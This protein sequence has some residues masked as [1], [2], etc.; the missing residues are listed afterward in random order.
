M[1][2]SAKIVGS[3]LARRPHL[4]HDG[5]PRQRGPDDL[6][7][8]HHHRCLHPRPVVSADLVHLGAV[9]SAG[10]IP[11][12]RGDAPQLPA[13]EAP[14]GPLSHA[15]R[16][17]HRDRADGSLNR[18][19]AA[20]GRRMRRT[21]A[22]PS[23]SVLSAVPAANPSGTATTPMRLTSKSVVMTVSP[24]PATDASTGRTVLCVAYTARASR[25]LSASNGTDRENATSTVAVRATSSAP[26]AP[27]PRNTSIAIGPT[28]ARPPAARS[29]RPPIVARLTR[30]RRRKAGRS[31]AAQA[32]DRAGNAAR[33]KATPMSDTGTLWKFR[34]KLM[35]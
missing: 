26:K 10:D 19:A 30:T 16:A 15:G 3:A 2:A 5:L 14:G 27:P 29:V 18:Q 21:S 31:F 8:R 34:A 23:S 9:R 35:A 11:G 33:E 24:N 13:V 12:R 17:V 7:R 6:R 4:G 32:A 22:R 25:L 28:T 20:T 1:V